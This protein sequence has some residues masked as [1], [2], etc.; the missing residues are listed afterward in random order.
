MTPEEQAQALSNAVIAVTNSVGALTN[1][2]DSL[3]NKIEFQQLQDAKKP[4]AP[5]PWWEFLTKFLGLPAVVLG[6]VLTFTQILS[7][8]KT[9]ATSTVLSNAQ[10]AS[11]NADANKLNAETLKLKLEIDDLTRKQ[12]T[13]HK[14]TETDADRLLTKVQDVLTHPP[15][16]SQP[17]RIIWKYIA[18]SLFL[19]GLG[20]VFQVIYT[21]WATLINSVENWL[22]NSLKVDW[23]SEESD[24]D[25]K[26]NQERQKR[27]EKLRKIWRY[28]VGFISPLPSVLDWAIRLSVFV[29]VALPLFDE[30]AAS[31][32]SNIR[33]S[34]II[35]AARGIDV[36]GAIGALKNVVLDQTPGP[37]AVGHR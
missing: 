15:A 22:Y 9:E 6:L 23:T 27:Y 2:V 5:V 36:V 24:D 11:A 26:K 10:T 12:A 30:T 7:G 32:G 14:L 34:Q 16:I 29:A 21:V 37:K 19:I 35:R 33:S 20:L 25:R 17:F 8:S 13:G 28:A 3:S 1:K 31:L 4:D 18:I